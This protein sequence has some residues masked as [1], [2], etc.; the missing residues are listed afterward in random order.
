MFNESDVTLSI[1][2]PSILIPGL[3]HDSLYTLFLFKNNV[4]KNAEPQIWS[5]LKNILEAQIML[6]LKTQKT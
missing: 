5:N 3:L 6:F 4:Y 1:G 2:H